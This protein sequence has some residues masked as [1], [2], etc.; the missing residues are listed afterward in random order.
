[1]IQQHLRTY[2]VVTRTRPFLLMER[3]NEMEKEVKVIAQGAY[4]KAIRIIVSALRKNVSRIKVKRA[5]EEE[6][7]KQLLD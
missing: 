6:R 7:R 5:L 1:M 3:L 2:L 4:E